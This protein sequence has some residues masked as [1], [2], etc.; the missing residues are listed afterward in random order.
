MAGNK[1]QFKNAY[2]EIQFQ[3]KSLEANLKNNLTSYILSH[4]YIYSLLHIF[5]FHLFSSR[6]DFVRTQ[7]MS[8]NN[9][10]HLVQNNNFFT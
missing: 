8:R 10:Q 3:S 6:R 4:F 9:L 2:K 1:S 5:L 7:V